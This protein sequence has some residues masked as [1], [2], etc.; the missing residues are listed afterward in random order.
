MSR[1]T[2]EIAAARVQEQKA[3]NK[4]RNVVRAGIAAAVVIG[5]G[6]WFQ[7]SISAPPTSDGV[8]S[9]DLSGVYPTDIVYGSE[10]APVTVIEYASVACIHCANF[11]ENALPDLLK[12]TVDQGKAKLIF[13]HFPY[14]RAGLEAAAAVTC[15]PKEKQKD[16]L[17]TL[18]DTQSEWARSE[19]PGKAALGELGLSPSQAKSAEACAI[20]QTTQFS[21]ISPA[22]EAR[23]EGISG[24]P[25]FVVGKNF[26][27]GFMG[28]DALAN[29]VAEQTSETK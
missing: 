24:T 17:K 7:T 15:L 26:Y 8:V 20:D 3:K 23:K 10:N 5:G 1:K 13:R 22:N 29:I 28:A 12:Q 16:A 21:V 27:R 14:D 11:H 9:K 2:K 4:I 6:A 19:T 25:T 18:F